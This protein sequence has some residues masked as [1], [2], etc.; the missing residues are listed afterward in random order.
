MNVKE[1]IESGILEAYVLGALDET[2]R[3]AVEANMAQYP[4]IASEVAAIEEAMLGYAQHYAEEPPAFLQDTVWN[5]IRQQAPAASVT[6]DIRPQIIPLG[7]EYSARIRWQ[8]AAVWIALIGSLLTNF[9]L[10]FERSGQQQQQLAMQ[11]QVDSLGRR[12]QHMDTMLTAYR[13]ERDML[14]DPDMQTVV[15]RPMKPGEKMGGMV[16]FNKQRGDLYLALHNMPE[17]PK[18]KQYQLWVIRDGK[19]VDM[20][21]IANEMTGKGGV[22]KMPKTV[23]AGEAFAI[24]LE[25]EGGSPTPTMEEI[26]VMGKAS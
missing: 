6:T 9:L 13:F 14:L 4:E 18:G 7:R 1:Y 26:K 10:W 17:P 23:T 19:P 5:T 15:M 3:A 11:Q 22:E 16:F 8:R 20:G 2:E 25:K 24:S 21:V 12:Q